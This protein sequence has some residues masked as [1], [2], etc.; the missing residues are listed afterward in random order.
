LFIGHFAVAFAAKKIAPTVSLGTLFLAAQLADLVWPVL[1]LLGIEKVEVRPGAT[2]FTPL[3]FVHYP[4]SHSLLALLVWSVAYAAAYAFARRARMGVALTL[5]AVVLSHWVLDFVTHAPDMPLAFGDSPRVGLGL[6]NSVGATIV[7]EGLLFIWGLTLYVKT[8]QPID[9]I[10]QRALWSLVA[11][12]IVIY[13]AAIF[14][15]PA[16]SA[17]AVAWTALSMWLI[18]AWGYWIDAHRRA[19]SA[20]ARMIYG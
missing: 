15:P 14:G 1:L 16:P 20:N 18:V 8:T 13:F 7:I 11:F 17:T 19:L 3:D 6:W 4:Y 2:A 9:K 10:G 12:L 5:A